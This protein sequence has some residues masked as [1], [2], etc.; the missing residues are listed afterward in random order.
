MNCNVCIYQDFL[1]AH[2]KEQILKTAAENGF[3]V[4]FFT[5]DQ[6]EEAKVC[7]QTCD[8]LYS[9]NQA[10]V[11]TAP[12]SLKWLCISSAGAEPFCKDPTLIP[13][14]DCV[15]TNSAGGYGLTIAEHIVMVT[16]MMLRRMP[17]FLPEIN[18]HIWSAPLPMKSILGNSFTML[19]TGNL[20]TTAALR[21]KAM[22]AAK[23]IGVSRSGVK[24]DDVYDEFYS[25][26]DLDK[27]LPE[28]K[29]LVMSL[30]STAETVNILDRR[31]LALLPK[32]AYIVNVGRGNAIDQEAL[33]EALNSGAIA[34]AALD[35]TV[36]EPLPADNPLWT[37]K[38]LVLTPHISGR[39]SLNYTRDLNVDMFC[40]NLV[41]YAAGK[42]LAHV[43]DRAR[44]Y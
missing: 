8:V 14:P 32:D 38:N 11:R 2:H 28:T 9:E 27:I 21:L 41:N 5:S 4:H 10:L 19:G 40:E 12:A 24:K 16:L 18:Q 20:G 26:D 43:V 23:I 31:R 36:P 42:P 7:L 17:D 39:F 33:V 6:F 44:G 3:V 30:P 35:V 1:E 25:T 34:G 29:I 15:L 13:S 37:A 22:G